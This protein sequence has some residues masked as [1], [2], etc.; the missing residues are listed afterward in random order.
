VIAMLATTSLGATWTSTSPDFGVESV[1][2][3]FGQVK[4]KILFTC[5]GYTFNGKT[6][7]MAEKNQHISD[8]LDGLRQVC[9]ISYL[10]P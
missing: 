6:F 10:K 8:H 9:Q 2:E 3:R 1:L 4:P 5:D 7:D